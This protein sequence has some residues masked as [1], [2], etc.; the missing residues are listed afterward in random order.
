MGIRGTDSRALARRRKMLGL[1]QHALAQAASISVER[2]VFHETGRA[3][4]LPD[5]LD[6]VRNVLR[7]RLREVNRE[8]GKSVGAA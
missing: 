2:L 6:R 4:L 7:C 5:E 3:L 8:V 1:T